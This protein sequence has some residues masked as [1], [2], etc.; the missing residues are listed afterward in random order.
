[1][2]FNHNLKTYNTKAAEI[3][4]PIIVEKFKPDS[5]LDVGCGIGTW[6]S[7]FRDFGVKSILGVDGD[8]VDRSLLRKF[9]D[10]ENFLNFDL[11]NELFLGK[12]FDL[13]LSLE[14]A[15]HIE[16]E[17]AN[18]FVKSLVNHGEIIV[19]SAA[20]PFQGGE[21]HL[22]EQWP[23]YWIEKFAKFQ[24]YPD[25]S[26]RSRIWEI[27]DIEFWYRQNIIVFTKEFK[28]NGVFDLVHPEH[29]L[30]KIN[31]LKTKIEDFEN[32]RYDARF[33]IYVLLKKF[34]RKLKS[35]ARRSKT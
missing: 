8:W 26:L 20:I 18:N 7:V 35:Y 13:V 24:L 34:L 4:V 30:Q 6:L 25:N 3:V 1:M 23:S 2:Q 15:E 32:G 31:A 5:V 10:E 28:K 27:K 22:N 12:K 21:N 9:I 19:F 16:E 17:Y 14:V 29:Y 33:Y 11:R